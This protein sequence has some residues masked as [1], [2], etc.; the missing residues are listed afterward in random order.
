MLTRLN[1]LVDA[2]FSLSLD[3]YG[4][5]YSNVSNLL[6]YMPRYVKIDRSLLSEIQSSTQKQHFVR[7]II[8]FCHSNNIIALAEG[9]E[10]SEELATVIRLGADL[11]QGYYTAKPSPE[12][13]QSIDN[14]IK[15]EIARYH[16]ELEDGKM[17][18]SYMAGRTNRISVN[19]LEKDNKTTIIIGDKN[20]T[21]RDLTIVG[22]PNKK[23]NL[24]IEILEGFD[25]RV[26]LENVSLSNVK[27]RPSIRMA[28]N[29]KLTLG[30]EGENRLEGGGIKVPEN[31]KLTF[32]GD[33]DLRIIYN[34]AECYGI[35]NGIDEAHGL[36]EF[37]QDGE[38]Y[39]ESSGKTIIGIG[40]GLGG[41]TRIHKGK[42]TFI[43]SGDDGVGI[44]S[45]KGGQDIMIHDCDLMMD[46]SFFRGVFVGSIEGNTKIDMW[47]SLVRI[48]ASGKEISVLG[49]VMGERAEIN[50]NN[51]S[52]KINLRSDYS[53]ALGSLSGINLVRVEKTALRCKC[54]GLEPVIYGGESEESFIY[55]DDVDEHLYIE[56]ELGLFT[57]IPETNIKKNR[58]ISSNW[59]NGEDINE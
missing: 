59:A 29:A 17:D 15:L 57:R 22:T 55:I 46:N 42:Y 26:V 33:G 38:I 16:H 5:G 4:T 13:I 9:V 10:T 54:I 53:A 30:L 19:A 56:T 21:F 52:L 20:A 44:G 6:R 35:G 23:S 43:L 12:I 45:I 49:T 39:L 47:R 31:S 24:H 36:L 7:E 51:M 14:N 58:T 50:I 3:D 48:T 2:G 28:E 32:E 41:D 37:Y 34:G 8:D 18:N 1:E 40:S 27:G 25:G 11:I